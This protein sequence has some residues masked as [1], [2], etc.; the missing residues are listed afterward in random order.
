[1]RG[2][3]CK[4]LGEVVQPVLALQLLHTIVQGQPR[5]FC[6]S[7][8][9]K[10]ALE[11]RVLPGLAALLTTSTN[12]PLLVHTL[13]LLTALLVGVAPASPAVASTLLPVLTQLLEEGAQALVAS[14]PSGSPLGRKPSHG[15]A[16]WP[17]TKSMQHG[18]RQAAASGEAGPGS[19]S[20]AVTST[21]SSVGAVRHRFGAA[22]ARILRGAHKALAEAEGGRGRGEGTG[23]PG[24]GESPETEGTSAPPLFKLCLVMEALQALSRHLDVLAAVFAQADA[25]AATSAGAVV[26][27]FG[28]LVAALGELVHR[29]FITMPIAAVVAAA[30]SMP[31]ADGAAGPGAALAEQVLESLPQEVLLRDSRHAEECER[32]GYSHG[33]L[34]PQG[35]A[36]AWHAFLAF[37]LLD[38]P[39]VQPPTLAVANSL[40]GRRGA[41]KAALVRAQALLALPAA[42]KEEAGEP[43]T[44]AGFGGRTRSVSS[45]APVR[46]VGGGGVLGAAAGNVGSMLSAVA[47]GSGTGTFTQRVRSMVGVG[48]SSPAS[49]REVAT[50]TAGPCPPAIRGLDTNALSG[51][52]GLFS[53]A[54]LTALALS[55]ITGIMYVCDAQVSKSAAQAGGKARAA[56]DQASTALTD[57]LSAQ[58]DSNA[59][60]AAAEAAGRA[61]ASSRASLPTETPASSSELLS[62]AEGL[63]MAVWRPALLS[64]AAPLATCADAEMLQTILRAYQ[65][66]AAAC[67]GLSLVSARDAFLV[68]LCHHALP[69]WRPTA[70]F[71]RTLALGGG[72]WG[73]H[74]PSRSLRTAV[75]GALSGLF[76]SRAHLTERHTMVFKTLFNM[77]HCLGNILGRSWLVVLDTVAQFSA[78][79][80][81]QAS[82]TPGLAERISAAAASTPLQD[83]VHPFPL[84]E[85]PPPSPALTYA[86]APTLPRGGGHM[87]MDGG[88]FMLGPAPGGAR[89][90]SPAAEP[91]QPAGDVTILHSALCSLFAATSALSADAFEHVVRALTDLTLSSLAESAMSS[92]RPGGPGS[93]Q[94]HGVSRPAPLLPPKGGGVESASKTPGA[95]DVVS[96][97][98]PASTPSAT[99]ADAGK[100]KG[101]MAASAQAHSRLPAAPPAASGSGLKAQVGTTGPPSPSPSSGGRALNAKRV[102]EG[103]AVQAPFALV[104]L[105]E[106]LG[107][108]LH[109]EGSWWG[110]VAPLFAS[111]AQNL[112]PHVRQFVV[113]AHCA[114]ATHLLHAGAHLGQSDLLQPIGLFLTCPFPDTRCMA[115]QSMQVILEGAGERL[116]LP[117]EALDSPSTASG[118]MALLGLLVRACDSA[119]GVVEGVS[120]TSLGRATKDYA[121]DCEVPSYTFP[122]TSRLPCRPPEVLLGL[123]DPH[124]A[125]A[126]AAAADTVL[127]AAGRVMQVVTDE[128]L[129]SLPAECVLALTMGLTLMARQGQ[130]VNAALTATATLWTVADTLGRV[131]STLPGDDEDACVPDAAPALAGTAAPAVWDLWRAIVPL[132]RSVVCA[133][134]RSDTACAP[135]PLPGLGALSADPLAGAK[136]GVRFDVRNAAV[137]TLFSSLSSHGS[138]MPGSLLHD[139][140]SGVCLPL[141]YD[142]TLRA[143]FYA[144]LESEA[145]TSTQDLASP[146]LSVRGEVLGRRGGQEVRARVHHSGDTLIKQWHGSR[147]QAVAGLTKVIAACFD[148]TLS[149]PWFHDVFSFVL[150]LLERA[151]IGRKAG[152]GGG[153]SSAGEG[154]ASTHGTG[155]CEGPADAQ[156]TE[157]TSWWSFLVGDAT[158]A[159]ATP[160][161]AASDAS[162]STAPASTP[163]QAFILEPVDVSV[164][165]VAALQEL[166][167][168]VCVPAG[169]ALQGAA[170]GYNVGMRVVNGALVQRSE[171]E[172]AAAQGRVQSPA[173]VSSTP[174][175]RP[176]HQRD[177]E[178]SVLWADVSS[179]LAAIC[180]SEAVAVDETDSLAVAVVDCLQAVL[181]AR[182]APS[183]VGS[184]AQP[185]CFLLSERCGPCLHLLHLVVAQRIRQRW[186]AA[187][188]REAS[189]TPLIPEELDGPRLDIA[190]NTERHTL[191]A[192]E[193]LA[194]ALQACSQDWSATG[195]KAP[196][197]ATTGLVSA[198]E[199]L[200]GLLGALAASRTTSL[201]PSMTG[202]DPHCIA[203]PFP[204]LQLGACKQLQQVQ[205]WA[206]GGLLPPP[207]AGLVLQPILQ[208]LSEASGYTRRVASALRRCVGGESREVQPGEASGIATVLSTLRGLSG[209]PESAEQGG[210]TLSSAAGLVFP[211]ALWGVGSSSALSVQRP[212]VTDAAKAKRL[213]RKAE[214]G[215][216]AL[217]AALVAVAGAAQTSDAAAHW[218]GVALPPPS[219]YPALLHNL[220]EA[221]CVSL[222][223]LTSPAASA[224]AEDGGSEEGGGTDFTGGMDIHVGAVASAEERSAEPLGTGESEAAPLHA[225]V[226]TTVEN[227]FN[228]PH[229]AESV[230]LRM[231]SF[232]AATTPPRPASPDVEALAAAH[233]DAFDLGLA[234]SP[235][236][237]QPAL[238]E[239]G[240]LRGVVSALSADP[241]QATPATLSRVLALTAAL[242][243][244]I[245]AGAL[246]VP[247]SDADAKVARQACSHLGTLAAVKW[248]QDEAV[249]DQ[250]W[251]VLLDRA[252]TL[253]QHG[254]PEDVEGVLVLLAQVL[255]LRGRRGAA[256]DLLGLAAA[257]LAA[258]S[259]PGVVRAVQALAT[260]SAHSGQ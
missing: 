250:A 224:G 7:P 12:Y 192:V 136:Q 223:P 84:S 155:S 212:I 234:S 201:L 72:A 13:R 197:D 81:R 20:T 146:G 134:Q 227:A 44:R 140:L 248:P 203:V 31:S 213:L 256:A 105:V 210:V 193:E 241:A 48:S 240:M 42:P 91:Q 127:A 174:S 169:V 255:Q 191:R 195:G 198:W 231:A 113:S 205:A 133:D 162:S 116:S 77:T 90:L 85:A 180:E 150:A 135:T 114:L 93:A 4:W 67:G 242:S 23:T 28:P 41:E 33:R 171:G 215:R 10:L 165:A 253:C 99:A 107:H 124:A 58:P 257:A 16:S 152:P 154:G 187:N 69:D 164:A 46:G 243:V 2:Q 183:P 21:A 88:H 32:W 131:L 87:G 106:T 176:S 47:G 54:H 259:E 25:V 249:A 206:S 34:T 120:S 188:P 204:A 80:P 75:H 50:A 142:V 182:S 71:G 117:T 237:S 112:S 170:E 141:V 148:H 144:A 45:E 130:H 38:V 70:G 166:S 11:A 29:A 17:A 186:L 83:L 151:V 30:A 229:P 247:C 159:S 149:L 225:A 161:R 196:D 246:Q 104:R 167:L 233:W 115:V 8:E 125:S 102:A 207:A 78:N 100:S 14:P 157:G 27:V 40:P 218:A 89:P 156:A 160:S 96:P 111:L 37:R 95:A 118:W 239:L 217:A 65:S 59:E 101:S 222:P 109:R 55:T 181:L 26:P 66:F 238:P 158:T 185:S 163:H 199:E 177:V 194:Q 219:H 235:A 6:S 122:G 138:N 36:K 123:R 153:T 103:R 172:D 63:A 19:K 258:S 244:G 79:L 168:L 126:G 200:L 68:S 137:Q 128:F 24:G 94:G 143:H 254:S 236:Q 221:W 110:T 214:A 209:A 178:R 184:P 252:H 260:A 108:N 119:V 73:R 92:S 82:Q 245:A 220:A 43:D 22:G 18:T 208:L 51:A 129:S 251:A 175:R 97:A 3:P 57:Q 211:L 202:G 5:L 190:T 39:D 52:P 173:V 64:L 1:M 230:D 189:D 9:F 61:R 145:S 74:P 226:L 76:R 132:L 147:M 35:L 179:A 49:P 98:Q 62:H 216:D 15:S 86:T 139:L 232:L 121:Q 60:V 228:L 56:A 53:I